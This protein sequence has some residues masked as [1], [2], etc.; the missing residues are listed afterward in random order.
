[1]AFSYKLLAV[2]YLFGTVCSVVK[3]FSFWW[4]SM[5]INFHPTNIYIGNTFEFEAN[6]V[7]VY[8]LC[9]SSDSNCYEALRIIFFIVEKLRD[10]NFISPEY[11]SALQNQRPFLCW[12]YSLQ[13]QDRHE[14]FYK[15]P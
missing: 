8:W 9:L 13:K 7:N 6:A 2:S 14:L 11:F 1:M 10:K 4:C 3:L 5:G 15:L 12:Q